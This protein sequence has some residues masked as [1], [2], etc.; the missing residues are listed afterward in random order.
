MLYPK[1]I[2]TVFEAYIFLADFTQISK[3]LILRRF[4]HGLCSICAEICV[5]S[6]R[7]HKSVGIPTGGTTCG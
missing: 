4:N 1:I 6:A 2:L 3:A 5:K 7:K